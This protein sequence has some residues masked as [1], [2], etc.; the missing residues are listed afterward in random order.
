MVNP[1]FWVVRNCKYLVFMLY[2]W[3]DT[4]L[5]NNWLSVYFLLVE[6][7]LISC[8]WA[9]FHLAHLYHILLTLESSGSHTPEINSPRG[10]QYPGHLPSQSHYPLDL[11]GPDCKLPQSTGLL[12]FR[13]GAFSAGCLCTQQALH[14][15][16][17][18]D[19]PVSIWARVFYQNHLPVGVDHISNISFPSWG[20]RKII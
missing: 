20:R 16:T 9:Q 15:G 11:W 18:W 17:A 5:S 14:H 1:P 7:T 10:S 12:S 13:H 19:R 3:L 8:V 6:Y 4:S 2:E